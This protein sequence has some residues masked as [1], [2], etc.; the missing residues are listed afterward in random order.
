MQRLV[1]E[2][3]FRGYQERIDGT[4]FLL[5]DEVKSHSTVKYDKEI[6][7]FWKRVRADHLR[8]V[9]DNGKNR[10]YSDQRKQK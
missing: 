7:V 2:V 4:F 3:V 8:E 1:K 9:E 6:H 5:V 10:V